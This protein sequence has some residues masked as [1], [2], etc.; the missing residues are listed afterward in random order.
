LKDSTSGNPSFSSLNKEELTAIT[1]F[2]TMKKIKVKNEMEELAAAEAEALGGA[3]EDDSDD[4]D[5]MSVDSDDDERPKKRQSA[6]GSGPVTVG[7]MA[8]DDDEDSEGTLAFHL[9]RPG[10]YSG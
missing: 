3:M 9:S 6:K 2:L 7:Q 5:A 8:A 4:D 10:I 1:E